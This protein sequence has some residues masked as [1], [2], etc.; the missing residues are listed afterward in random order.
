VGDLKLLLE[1]N[2]DTAFEESATFSYLMQNN[3]RCV[4]HV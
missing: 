2:K 3:L 1:R 4:F